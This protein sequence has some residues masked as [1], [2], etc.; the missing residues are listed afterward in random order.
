M[1]RIKPKQDKIITIKKYANRRLYDTDRSSYITLEDLCEMVKD[2]YDFIVVDAK[3]GEDITRSVLTQIIVEQESRGDGMLPTKF[4]RQLI[5][6]Y[7]GKMQPY[8]PDYLE[9]T[10]DVLVKNQE[11][12]QDQMS[13]SFE[14]IEG[15]FPVSTFNDLG[16]KNMEMFETA[17]RRLTAFPVHE[18]KEEKIKSI[19]NQIK[20]LEKELKN[21]K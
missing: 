15:M 2:E 7:G 17:M 11:S 8:I 10:I 20:E 3:T 21:L 12:F 13:K 16:R 14:T 1:A 9:Q 6:F 18:S 5:G 19:E 4:L